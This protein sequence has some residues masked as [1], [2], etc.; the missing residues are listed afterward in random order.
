MSGN[1]VKRTCPGAY[2]GNAR[3]KSSNSHYGSIAVIPAWMP[4]SGAMD[5]DMSVA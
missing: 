1:A 3:K 5:G 2:A 4:E